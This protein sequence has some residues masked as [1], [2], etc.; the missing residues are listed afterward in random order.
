MARLASYF[1][2]GRAD[3]VDAA[4]WAALQSIRRAGRPAAAFWAE[5]QAKP[6]DAQRA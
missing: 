3:A 2:N 4:F 6:Q 1:F 5:L